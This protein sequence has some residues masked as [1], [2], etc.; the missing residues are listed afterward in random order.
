M[1]WVI[2]IP[3][4]VTGAVGLGDVR[5]T[6]HGP[7]GLQPVEGVGVQKMHAVGRWMALGFAGSVE[8]G[9]RAVNDFSHYLSGVPAGAM[10]RPGFCTWHWARRVRYAFARLPTEAKRGGLDLLV[11]G[12]SPQE[13]SFPTYTHG[14]ILRCPTFEL[15]VIPPVKARSIGSGSHVPAFVEELEKLLAGPEKV[16]ELIQLE[17]AGAGHSALLLS[18]ALTE[19]IQEV[20]EAT[21]SEHLHLCFVR[22]G[23]VRVGTNDMESLTPEIVASRKMPPVARTFDEFRALAEE[24]GIESAAAVA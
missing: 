11:L 8:L 22:P 10:A 16:F 17:A 1:T 23:E 13:S 20:G 2:G 3:S 24:L 19:V 14:Y 4:L 21:V 9:F 12:A 6:L 18:I 15:E 7:G 5:I